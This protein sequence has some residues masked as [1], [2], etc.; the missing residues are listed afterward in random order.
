MEKKR[1]RCNY[2]YYGFFFCLLLLTS[3]GG[4]F[5]KENLQGSLFFFSLYAAMQATLETA[6]LVFIGSLIERFCKK[7][8]FHAFIGLTFVFAALHIFEFV[9]ERIIDLSVWEA[10][11]TFI[12]DES[13]SN[14]IYL[15][16]A[17]GV[18]MWAWALFF[19]TVALF[20]FLGILWYRLLDQIARKKPLVIRTDVFLLTFF[21]LPAGLLFWDYSAS[22]AIHPDVYS[23]CIKAL[24]WKFTFLQPKSVVVSVPGSFPMPPEEEAVFRSIEENQTVLKEKP[25]IYLFIVESL[26]GDCITEEIAPHLHQFKKG[27]LYA[28]VTCSNANATPL[29]WFSIFHSEYPTVWTWRQKKDWKGGSAPL[30]LLKK[31]GYKIHLY[32][33]A[34]LGYYNMEKL[35]FGKGQS[36][37]DTYKPFHHAPP[38][39]AAESDAKAL[40][41]LQKDLAS[42]PELQKGQVFIVF[43]DSTH[44]DYSWPKTRK[45]KFT[46]FATEFAYFKLFY[47]APSLEL[48]KNRYRNAVNYVDALFGEFLQFL[49]H[50]EEAIVV[51]TGDH[52]EEFMEKGH[53]FHL[54]H[55]VDEQMNIPLFMRFGSKEPFKV[56]GLISQIDIFPSIFHALSGSPLELGGFKGQSLFLKNRWPFAMVARFNASRAPYEFCLHNGLHK[57]TMR[58]MNRKDIFAK[59]DLRICSFRDRQDRPLFYS[60]EKVK[61][62][63]QAQFGPA[64]EHL[65]QGI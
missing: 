52:G 32:S 50:P 24:P 54:T 58:F 21:C 20:P 46:P 1:I 34:N 27:A 8:F 12:L 13:F 5:A 3:T 36:L 17:S 28:D 61:E 31:W 40:S 6:L 48:I 14:F 51:F 10:L 65:F 60:E 57:L 39:S 9:L 33:S 45:P 43:L 53:L 16:D 55:L 4:V 62:E 18:P 56:D 23:A 35:L 38:V 49:P 19:I 11:D 22:R 44:F 30:A 2:L 47:T 7:I 42:H 63:I 29:S 37:V 25:N 59:Q 41:E 26:R 15:L 64:L